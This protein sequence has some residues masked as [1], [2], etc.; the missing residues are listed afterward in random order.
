MGQPFLAS[1]QVLN[2]KGVFTPF[3]SLAIASGFVLSSA[4]SATVAATP[5]LSAISLRSTPTEHQGQEHYQ[6]GDYDA[7]ISAWQ[8]ATQTYA[9]QNNVLA[10]AQTLSNIA[11]AQQQQGDWGGAQVTLS[12]SG[13]LLTDLNSPAAQGIQAQVLSSQAYLKYNLGDRAAALADWQAAVALYPTT[14][15]AL[16]DSYAAGRWYSQLAIAQTHHS[17]GQHEAAL[18]QILHINQALD[19]LSA[20][21]PES[22]KPSPNPS[23]QQQSLA[24]HILVPL[25]IRAR[26][27][28]GDLLRHQGQLQASQQRLEEALALASTSLPSTALHSGK[29]TPH[30]SIQG[31]LWLSLGHT[32][33]AQANRTNTTAAQTRAERFYQKATTVSETEIQARLALMALWSEQAQTQRLP[34]QQPEHTAKFQETW[35]TVQT[36]LKTAP[37]QRHHLYSRIQ[38]IYQMNGLRRAPQKQVSAQAS[39]QTSA[40]ASETRTVSQSSSQTEALESLAYE[41]IQ[42]AYALDDAQAIAQALGALGHLYG[43]QARWDKAQSLTQEAIQLAEANQHL[44]VL[45]PLQ[46]QLAHLRLAQLTSPPQ[47]SATTAASQPGQTKHHRRDINN[48]TSGTVPK[49]VV[50]QDKANGSVFQQESHKAAIAAYKTV[51]HTLEQLAA[52]KIRQEIRQETGQATW[53]SHQATYQAII[54]LLQKTPLPIPSQQ[55][56]RL[57]T[58]TTQL[59]SLELQAILRASNAELPAPTPLLFQPMA[60]LRSNNL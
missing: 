1:Q 21:T 38:L 48:R 35:T 52:P 36:L 46:G 16:T 50:S 6:A 7:A 20:H 9:S 11:L 18:Q 41:S 43:Q 12:T 24:A 30:S 49:E 44:E 26:R 54:A 40:Q 25:K 19:A 34:P 55:H 53:Q 17:L 3:L 60:S 22:S 28:W 2:L 51:L 27:Q 45:Y 5:S 56:Q 57:K 32:A 42:Q 29:T 33:R 31:K 39:V 14:V 58:L 59:K 8:A 23:A 13:A 4:P 47:D 37:S 15:G 10:Q